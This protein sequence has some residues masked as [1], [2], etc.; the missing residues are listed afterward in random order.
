MRAHASSC[1]LGDSPPPSR[2]LLKLEASPAS[3][4]PFASFSCSHQGVDAEESATKTCSPP[5]V[6]HSPVNTLRIPVQPD[7]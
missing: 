5:D 1:Q 6:T 3:P 4:A 7:E 2:P